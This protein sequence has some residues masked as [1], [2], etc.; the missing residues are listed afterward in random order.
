MSVHT[1]R[2]CKEV[3]HLYHQTEGQNIG[4]NNISAY[5]KFIGERNVMQCVLC[6]VV[7]REVN[8]L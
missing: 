7:F 5:W 1:Y 3:C 2:V 8:G 4:K 6:D